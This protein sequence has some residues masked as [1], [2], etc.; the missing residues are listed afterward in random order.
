MNSRLY[1]IKHSFAEI[2]GDVRDFLFSPLI[3][4]DRVGQW[5]EMIGVDKKQ[6]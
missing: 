3:D 6:L 5:V 4:I 1:I 2:V